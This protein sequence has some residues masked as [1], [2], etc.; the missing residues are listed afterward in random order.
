[1]LLSARLL[2]IIVRN[3]SPILVCWL[4]TLDSASHWFEQ[5]TFEVFTE[6]VGL[7]ITEVLAIGRLQVLLWEHFPDWREVSLVIMY[8]RWKL[9][10]LLSWRSFRRI[11]SFLF[12]V[13]YLASLCNLISVN[14]EE[15]PTG[16]ELWATIKFLPDAIQHLLVRLFAY[17]DE[18]WV[19]VAESI[20][21][22]CHSLHDILRIFVHLDYELVFSHVVIPW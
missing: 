21:I 4:N 18:S 3:Y 15:L 1:M 7:V 13:D 11:F 6:H 2:L 16:H 12:F 14:W 17:K 10:D 9:C 19:A 20:V 22:E 8:A 5:L